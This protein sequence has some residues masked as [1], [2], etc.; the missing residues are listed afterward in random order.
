MNKKNILL[1]LVI[2][3][4][5][6]SFVFLQQR[7][8]Q[9]NIHEK[10]VSLYFAT[11][12][13]MYLQAEKRNISGDNIYQATL[14]ELIKGPESTDYNKTIP[15]GVEILDID[16]KNSIATLNFN[17]AL[18][19][20]HWGGSTGETM[21]VYSIVNTMTQFSEIKKVK[22]IIESEEIDTLA[23]HM[24]LSVP[25]ERNEKIIKE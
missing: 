5:G 10:D 16:I 9:N 12:D 3:L 7:N 4:I 19:E 15:Q 17:R 2:F 24:D 6:I 8:N 13:A 18:R 21:T 25:L 22:I 11:K 20:N 14:E 23:G 1:I